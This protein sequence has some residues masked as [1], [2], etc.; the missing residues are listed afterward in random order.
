MGAVWLRSRTELRDRWKA[1]LAVALLAG[2]GAGI[3]M[4]AFA[5]Y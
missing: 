5:A 1:W 2:V 3:A 4:G